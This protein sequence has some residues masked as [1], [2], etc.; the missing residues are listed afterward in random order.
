MIIFVNSI[1]F[2]I[3]FV[4]LF[5][6]FCNYK[7]SNFF[8][9]SFK[10]QKSDFVKNCETK[11]CIWKWNSF[12]LPSTDMSR[13]IFCPFW[14]KFRHKK[15]W[16]R[17]VFFCKMKIVTSHGHGEGGPGGIFFGLLNSRLSVYHANIKKVIELI[18][19]LRDYGFGG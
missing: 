5:Q 8:L 2:A 15:S 17:Y 6:K 19:Q 14:T 11:I 18:S 10:F 13:V 4:K 7:N 12:A 3:I 9:F 16:E 1:S